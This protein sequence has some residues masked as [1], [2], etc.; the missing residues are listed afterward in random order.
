M[1][2]EQLAAAADE[3]MLARKRERVGATS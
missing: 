2:P 3:A 1:T